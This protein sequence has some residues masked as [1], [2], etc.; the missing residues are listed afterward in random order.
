MPKPTPT[1]QT[2]HTSFPHPQPSFQSSNGTTQ[3]SSLPSPLNA[4]LLPVLGCGVKADTHH[5]NGEMSYEMLAP[6]PTFALPTEEEV[7][8]QM[9]AEFA[10]EIAENTDTDLMPNLTPA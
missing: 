1:T 6:D 8:A 9:E 10:C 4:S 7:H 5:F 2:L 3:L